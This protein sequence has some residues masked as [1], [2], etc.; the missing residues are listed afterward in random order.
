MYGQAA[1]A[2]QLMRYENSLWQYI[3]RTNRIATSENEGKRQEL[4][5]AIAL[6]Y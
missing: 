5:M 1:S 6:L 2:A 4:R 3:S